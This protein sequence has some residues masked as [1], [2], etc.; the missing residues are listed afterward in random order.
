MKISEF[1]I[2]NFKNI[3]LAEGK[4]LPDFVVICGGNGSGKSS[5]LEALLTLRNFL[6][7]QVDKHQRFQF[8]VNMISSNSDMCTIE[9]TFEFTDEEIGFINNKFDG[10]FTLPKSHS[11]CIALKKPDDPDLII[12]PD[13]II[14]ELTHKNSE[15]LVGIEGQNL[16]VSHIL[17]DHKLGVSVFDYF[18]AI[19]E[20]NKQNI[21]NWQSSYLHRN[22]QRQVLIQERNKFQNIKQYLL[23][24][25]IDDL[26]RIQ[27]AQKKGEDYSIDSLEPTREFFKRFFAPMEFIDIDMTRTPF[28][29]VISTPQGNIDIDNLSSGEKE[30]LFT[31]VH[32]QKFKTRDSIILF[33]EPDAHLH[34]ELE[35]NYLIALK[36]LSTGN[37]FFLT[38]HS[39]NMMAQ[40]GSDS[41]FTIIKHPE[42]GVNQF[43]KVTDS[44]EKH[45]LLSEIMGSKGFVSL[46]RKIVFIEGETSSIDIEIFEKFYPPNEFE[47]SFIPAGDSSTVRNVADKVNKLL[48]TSIG[49][50]SFYSIIDGDY[51]RLS[52]DPTNGERLFQLSAYH[53]E[54]VL[55]DIVIINQVLKDLK[56]SAYLL[57]SPHE[58]EE[59]L[60]ELVLCES[61]INTYAKAALDFE[62]ARLNKEFQDKIF[63]SQSGVQIDYSVIKPSFDTIKEK[64]TEELKVSLMNDTW[65]RKCKGRDLLKAL[66]NDQKI[67]Y[68]DLKNL[69]LA[70]MNKSNPPA[71][72]KLIMDKIIES[73]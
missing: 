28:Q 57:S 22:Q 40:T 4:N 45:E 72:L 1:R 71:E 58:L 20:V 19:R 50:E 53:I 10:K 41:L 13:D 67:R 34:P 47:I 29:F 36:E 62:I 73:N 23:G 66:S 33:D 61:H 8:D 21:N 6:A 25:K 2:E 32:F 51:S 63:S 30:V 17:Y 56:G 38:T 42:D 69:I 48:T 5:I 37:Q 3:K 7:G 70:K 14:D 55:L 18:S 9:A 65:K 26:R 46:N 43:Q 60:K 16:A 35:R 24:I 11:V 15:F 68:Q 12:N 64:V 52:D 44:E 54:N 31:Y 49:Y 59:K 27:L 39:P